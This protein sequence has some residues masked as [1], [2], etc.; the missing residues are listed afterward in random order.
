[1]NN[2]FEYK[3]GDIVITRSIGA[4]EANV[5]DKCRVI[6]IGIEHTLVERLSDGIMYNQYSYRFELIKPKNLTPYGIVTFCKENYK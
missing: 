5:G 1:M 2:T 3:V 4:D 6:V